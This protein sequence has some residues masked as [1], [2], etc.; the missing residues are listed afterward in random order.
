MYTNVRE[1]NVQNIV[2]ELHRFGHECTTN[3]MDL[4][5]NGPNYVIGLGGGGA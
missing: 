4:F 5:K 1:E 3:V 2:Q